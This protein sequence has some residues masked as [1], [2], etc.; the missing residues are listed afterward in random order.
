MTAYGTF[1]DHIINEEGGNTAKNFFL[2][3]IANELA[4]AN[5]LK[6]LELGFH[7]ADPEGN[8][9]RDQFARMSADCHRAIQEAKN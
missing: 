8:Q 4:E 9:G 3:A 1:E 6:R 2:F 7:G 5:R